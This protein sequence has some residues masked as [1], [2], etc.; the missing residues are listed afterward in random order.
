MLE[1]YSKVTIDLWREVVSLDTISPWRSIETRLNLERNGTVEKE[2]D[3]I[4]EAETI[5]KN[6]GLRVTSFLASG[7]T[8]YV[9]KNSNKM[10]ISPSFLSIRELCNWVATHSEELS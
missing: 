5:M 7:K 1:W 2:L 9:V 4:D 10:S 3:I 6:N 8:Q